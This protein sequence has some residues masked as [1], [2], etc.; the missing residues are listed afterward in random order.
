MATDLRTL[1]ALNEGDA[2]FRAWAQGVHAQL[3]ACGLVV[4]ADTGQADLTTITAPV[5]GTGF[6]GYKMY[7]FDDA[8]Q[9]TKPI[10]IKVEFGAGSVAAR[11]ALAMTVGTLTNGAGGFPGITVTPRWNGGG[12][13]NPG[14]TQTRDSLASGAQDEPSGGRFWIATPYDPGIQSPTC[15]L[16]ER[17]KNGDGTVHSSGAVWVSMLSG[18]AGFQVKTQILAHGLAAGNIGGDWSMIA[19]ADGSGGGVPHMPNV[20]TDLAVAP[21]T[22]CFGTWL[23][24]WPVHYRHQD[25]APLSPFTLNHLDGDHVY[26]PLGINLSALTIPKG[27]TSSACAIALPWE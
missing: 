18:Q 26:M 21:L 20:G 5:G 23:Y 14:A 24:C 6:P 10:F 13:V 11:L 25:L 12:T 27:G 2:T 17:L 19:L 22:Y 9:A 8:M 16:V 3:L 1:P 7:R 15:L 4:T